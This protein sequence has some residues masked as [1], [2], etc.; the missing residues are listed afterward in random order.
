[1]SAPILFCHY[2]NSD[3]LP[4]VFQCARLSNPEK[5]IVLLGDDDNRWIGKAYGISHLSF[6]DFSHGEEIELFDQLYRPVQGKRHNNMAG[7]RDWL[8]FVFKRWFYVYNFLA[9]HN[10]GE[11]WHF[12]TDNM[13]LDSLAHHEHKFRTYD[14]TEQCNGSCLNGFIS[15]PSIVRRYI[16]N[17]NALYARQE[18]LAVQQKEFDEVNPSYAFTEMRAYEIFRDKEEIRSIRLNTTM[19]DTSF[20]DAICQDHHMEVEI[21]PS[22]RK[23][24]KV[25]LA[26]NGEFFC[27][28][29][30]GG[31]LVRMN[32][33][34]LSWVPTY[35]FGLVLAH[36]SR[37][38]GPK[39]PPRPNSGD[40]PTL[41][42]SIPARYIVRE[43][44]RRLRSWIRKCRI[45]A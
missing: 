26:S 20:D 5:E 15:S 32:S 38:T 19:E 43:K 31:G 35:V 7:G 29:K 45:G 34:N 40:L 25:L 11:F 4:Y 8:N 14:C 23:I 33:L 24:K 30:A 6:G 18:F 16:R 44:V 13:I 22:G 27:R 36:A 12:D 39:E 2:G 1:M 42:S 9:A 17:I 3:Y 28:D 41:C 10:I 21:L 37:R